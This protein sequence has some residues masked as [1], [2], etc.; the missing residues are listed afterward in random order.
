MN[1]DSKTC[2]ALDREQNA[3]VRV[4]EAGAPTETIRNLVHLKAVRSG[5]SYSFC[6]SYS[7]IAWDTVASSI[8]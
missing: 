3:T 7:G 8:G 6:A 2:I 5:G 4:A 1:R